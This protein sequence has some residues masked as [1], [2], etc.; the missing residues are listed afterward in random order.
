MFHVVPD[1]FAPDQPL[2]ITDP[3]ALRAMA[4]PARIAIAQHLALDGPA[5]ATECA[6]FTGLSPSACSYHLR[7]LARYGFIE[8]DPDSAPDARNRPW[9]ARAMQVSVPE[10]AGQ[11]EAMRSAA[12]LLTEQLHTQFT[13]M[14]ARYY[15]HEAQYPAAWQGAA[16]VHQDVVHVTP[17]ELRKLAEALQELM[18]PLRRLD[19]AARPPGARR[20]HVLAD[21]IPELSPGA[22]P[23][24]P[25][26]DPRDHH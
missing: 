3:R 11:S 16:Q 20:V 24:M 9:R 5:T 13:A 23:H 10:E 21:L 26:E 2:A 8:P 25:P 6:R 22:E 14:R 17:D 19:R 12:A 15:R 18:R 1:A 4:H 7:T